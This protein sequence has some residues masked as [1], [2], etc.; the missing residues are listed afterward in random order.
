MISSAV[1]MSIFNISIDFDT[2]FQKNLDFDVGFDVD[3]SRKAYVC[4]HY[5]K[6]QYKMS[7]I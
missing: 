4:V 6:W 2:I 3:N 7:L 1:T 5:I